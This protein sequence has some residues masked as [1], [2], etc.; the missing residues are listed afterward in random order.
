[1]RLLVVYGIKT[2]DYGYLTE[3]YPARRIA[4]EC[5]NRSIPLRFLFPPDVPAFLAAP[6]TARERSGTICLIRGTV[7]PDLVMH[8]EESGY[9]CVNSSRSLRLA[10]DKLASFDFLSAHGWPTPKT[11]SAD[12][13][14]QP[15][16]FPLIAKPRFG[17]RGEGV[18]LLASPADIPALPDDTILQ[19]YIA[20]SRGRDLRA[21]FAG[22]RVL[23]V[24]ERQGPA[25]ALVSNSSAGGTMSTPPFG[26]QLPEKYQG[27]VLDIAR[28]SGL[29]YGSVDFLYCP[30]DN[31]GAAAEDED[32]LNLTVC[33]LNGSPGFEALEKDCG[34]NIAG[35]LIDALDERALVE[36]QADG[37]A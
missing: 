13:F 22:R 15:A 33:E 7:S 17:S 28:E 29:W 16:K 37:S 8:I 12:Q 24:V 26:A 34:I 35:A 6:S 31:S 11:M 21:F 10:N 19:E 23:A 3:F 30:S 20:Y 5:A 9:R 25:E 4:G 1:M 36:S 18:K 27:L 2:A 14:T 32:K